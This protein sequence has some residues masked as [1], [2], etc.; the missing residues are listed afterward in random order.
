MKTRHHT[1]LATLCGI[2]LL[3]VGMLTI[4]CSSGGPDL[5][6]VEGRVTLDGKPLPG[7]MVMFKPLKGRPS[8]AETDGDG[9]Y[10]LDYRIDDSGA[11]LG[12]H[13]VTI[14]TFKQADGLFIKKD[15]PERVPPKYNRRTS[16]TAEVKAG[17]N[18]INFDL[19][20]R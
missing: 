1:R 6:R 12:T 20:A 17:L 3:A 7:A 18:E 8:L 19:L 2:A 13:T 11:L 14:S 15:V 4:G 9:H 16:L 5:G 10:S